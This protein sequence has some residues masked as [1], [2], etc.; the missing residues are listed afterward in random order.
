MLPIA[1]QARNLGRYRQI[2]QVLVRHGFGFVVEQLGLVNL[3][4][5]PRRLILRVPPAP[6]RRV[7]ER[8][9][10][11]L[12]ELGPTF[13][14]LGQ[15]LSTRPDVLPADFIEE[16]NKLQD[17]V[18]PFSSALAVATIEF[19]LGRPIGQLFR[20]F[21]MQ[22][23]AA[24]SLGQVH[25]AVLHTGE[26]V[27][28]KVQRPDIAGIIETDLGIVTDLA[29]LA[30]ERTIFGTHYDLVELANEFSTTLRDELN[31]LREGSHAERFRRN[32]A[33][34]KMVHIPTVYWDYCTR[35]VLTSE[36]L[37]GI[38][39]N[40]VAGLDAARMD[41]PRLARH[42]LQL[43][44]EEVFE[45]GFFHADPHPGNFFALP[46]EV[47]GAVDFG[48]VSSLDHETTRQLL[49]LL[50]ALID[51]DSDGIVRA[52]IRLHIL[53]PLDVTPVL[54][55][56]IQRF[57]DRYV[58]RPLSELSFRGMGDDV[59]YLMRRYRLHMPSPLAL[60]LKTLIM[61]E[62][63]GLQ[64]DP[65]LD[66]FSIARPYA[67]RAILSQLSPRIIAQQLAD[68]ARDVTE[69]TFALP[70]QLGGVLQRLDAGELVVK[71]REE[72]LQR[73]AGALLGAANRLA[74]ALVLSALI[75]ALGLLA[76]AVG[77]GQWSGPTPIILA[78][79]GGLG[80]FVTGL[81]LLFALL[82]GRDA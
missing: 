68:H 72:E 67:R 61:A 38:K 16:L 18:P 13:V 36:R 33:G 73:L 12:V 28:V 17:T 43:I 31:Y 51:R 74:V 52:L 4:S 77:I 76:L 32:F 15:L 42:S 48:Q 39:I 70:G 71:T 69:A 56:E 57:I 47:I 29:E 46:G 54:R 19:E 40:N 79:L 55:R 65:E 2:A 60:L 24:A 21:S 26:Q 6:P 34:N 23:L 27:V 22:P 37:Y 82:H 49:L 14:K 81:A 25:A 66:V 9:R 41:R 8:L 1:R 5:L 53:S 30:Q 62:G 45:H 58:D 63:T 11:A 50:L 10:L 3:L 44:I 80:V 7:A 59:L 64:I 78:V 35:R 75:I 20:E